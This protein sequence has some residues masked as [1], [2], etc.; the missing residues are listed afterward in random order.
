M[1]GPRTNFTFPRVVE[2]SLL[3]NGRPCEVRAIGRASDRTGRLART[4]M[5]EVLDYSPDVIVLSN[6]GYMETAHLFLP[7]WLER[8]ADGTNARPRGL[9]VPYR[10]YILRP[11]WMA[12]AKL[13]ARVDGFLDP[14][15]PR[16][17]T[18]KV[19]TDLENYIKQVQRVG[20]P[21]VILLDQPP[22]SSRYARWFPG[23]AARVDA[24]H[25]ALEDMVTRLESPLVERFYVT[26]I[27]DEQFGG[28]LEVAV[29]DGFHYSP[30]L[31]RAIGV[32]LAQ[33]LEEW[34]DTQPHLA[35]DDAR[36]DVG[37]DDRA[38]Q[39]AEK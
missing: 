39:P 37:V 13:Q 20:S 22:P 30:E 14:H 24:M 32:R 4:W 27:I 35:L 31:H 1:G 28:D 19:T 10:K 9:G 38:P 21:L 6:Y 17:M 12:L 15:I 29:P 11:L 26:R 34:A 25:E 36:A 8:H 23:M 5:S 2:E 3:R 16:N 18:R 7:R 33:R